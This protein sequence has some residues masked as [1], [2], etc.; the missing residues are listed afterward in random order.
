MFTQRR[1]KE[2]E[3]EIAELQ[4]ELDELNDKSQLFSTLRDAFGEKD[5]EKIV[6]DGYVTSEEGSGDHRPDIRFTLQV[7]L[8]ETLIWWVVDVTGR[9][10]D[11][12]VSMKVKLNKHD[13]SRYVDIM[14]DVDLLDKVN[15]TDYD[16]VKLILDTGIPENI[17]FIWDV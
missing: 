13:D 17:G 14:E 16:I 2:I 12:D 1:R 5:W 8:H 3:D 10:S 9:H 11:F 6:V 4:A 15:E 7:E